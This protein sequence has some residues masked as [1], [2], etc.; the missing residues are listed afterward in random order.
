MATLL[1]LVNILAYLTSPMAGFV[2][3]SI[4]LIAI[5]QRRGRTTLEKLLTMLV[6]TMPLYMTPILPGLHHIASWT[7]VLLVATS[8]AAVRHIRRMSPFFVIA[9]LIIV[10]VS[11][12][13]VVANSE[14]AD[15]WYY[16]A[17]FLLFTIPLI[18]V[19]ETRGWIGET[20]DTAAVNRLL[21]W[22]AATQLAM[23]L[24]VIVQWQLHSR[25][26]VSIGSI[27]FF[28]ERVTYDLTVPA[29]SVLSGL[30]SVGIALAPTLWRHGRPAMA[31]ILAVVS[32]AAI[33]ANSSR[34]GIVVGA[35]VLGLAILFPPATAR[36]FGAR[37]AIIP[38]GAL[39]WWMYNLYES[40][41]R[42]AVS[43]DFLDD[44]GRLD[45]IQ[46]AFHL[47][48]SDVE[49]A[50]WGVGYADYEGVL[51]HNFAVETLVSSGYIVGS[52]VF[53]MIVGLLWHLR[54]S[55]W[56][57]PVWA[58]L[59]ASMFF[60][61]FY[62]VKAAIVVAILMVAMRAVNTAPAPVATPVS[63]H[64]KTPGLPTVK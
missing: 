5:S 47:L 38:A 19:Y 40:S 16:F 22:L 36:K 2:T 48:A 32:A 18:L 14:G 23:A 21:G 34:T 25:L 4:S 26:G 62:A 28:V 51:P 17:Q 58:L 61:G 60:A 57:Y 11:A 49:V 7:T 42:G 46:H 12:L 8:I 53:M 59:G 64:K 41:A 10:A 30:L 35:V 43:A 54:R 3:V 55:D 20:L 39:A 9:I 13:S 15:G 63:E 44:N 45:T 52:F 6:S 37:L 56:Q 27:S 24:G 33:V 50:L 29:Y 1:A 31:I